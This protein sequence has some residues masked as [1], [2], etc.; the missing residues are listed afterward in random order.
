MEEREDIDQDD[1]SESLTKWISNLQEKALREEIKTERYGI[2][3][4]ERAKLKK[5]LGYRGGEKKYEES[6]W[7]T[8]EALRLEKS[9]SKDEEENN[10]RTP[11]F[12]ELPTIFTRVRHET[13]ET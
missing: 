3:K 7:Y 6:G 2:T 8:R 12:G 9:G 11:G 13:R 10:E 1:G 5:L 4:S